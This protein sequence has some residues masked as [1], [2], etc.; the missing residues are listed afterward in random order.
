MPTSVEQKTNSNARLQQFLEDNNLHKKDFAEMIG[1]TLSYV[2]S[3]IGNE[4][5]FS[6]R[7]TTIERIAIVLN[8]EADS[9]P[10][11]RG[12]EEP[13]LIDQGVQFLKDKQIKMGLTNVQLLKRFPRSIR[14]DI[15]DMWRGALPLPIDWNMLNTIGDVLGATAD[16][17]Y[18]YW[19]LRLQQHLI[20]GGMDPL[21]NGMLIQSMF[22]GVRGFLSAKA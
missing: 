19:E 12:S 18:P 10:E 2:Y 11:Y 21:T 3:L 13:R 5:P 20:A 14:V 9:F 8:T 15:V 22:K 4:V 16:D 7:S 6:T 17:L 1:V